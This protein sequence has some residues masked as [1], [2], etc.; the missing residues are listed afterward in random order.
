[1]IL[2]FKCNYCNSIFEHSLT[3]TINYYSI[4]PYCSSADTNIT[5]KSKLLIER[6]QK[7]EKINDTRRINN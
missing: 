5:E 2:E 7:I 4:C 3:K 1:M 6:K